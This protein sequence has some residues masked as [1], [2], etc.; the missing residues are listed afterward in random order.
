MHV[1]RDTRETKSL[2]DSLGGG[3]ETTTPRSARAARKLN[4]KTQSNQSSISGISDEHHQRPALT[5]KRSDSSLSDLSDSIDQH[6]SNSTTTPQ[7]L[8]D[9]PSPSPSQDTQHHQLSSDN[10]S[11]S[12]PATPNRF[13]KSNKQKPSLRKTIIKRSHSSS[14]GLL[15]H[16]RGNPKLNRA[17]RLTEAQKKELEQTRLKLLESLQQEEE[18]IKASQHPILLSLQENVD[19]A[20]ELRLTQARQKF[21]QLGAYLDRLNY[22]RQQRIWD[23]WKDAKI[24]LQ[25][26]MIVDCQIRLN[27]AP[28]EFLISNDTTSFSRNRLTSLLIFSRS[29]SYLPSHSHPDSR[30]SPENLEHESFGVCAGFIH[31]R[32]S[33]PEAGAMYHDKQR[34][35]PVV[36]HHKIFSSK[37]HEGGAEDLRMEGP[38]GEEPQI[39][40]VAFKDSMDIIHRLDRQRVRNHAVWQLSHRDIRDDLKLIHRH[41]RRSLHN[42]HLH[43]HPYP[44]TLSLPHP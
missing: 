9:S 29:A 43:H 37:G 34:K 19:I 15:R 20:K 2:I 40:P 31:S 32:Y 16:H 38:Q 5:P 22:E 42:H 13:M 39:D 25:T 8:I 36:Q 26:E 28:F 18:L 1:E 17:R 14:F 6:S 33:Q 27:R 44:T 4:S 41:R 3:L 12:L 23:T 21:Q 24:K 35:A 7:L 30:L 10:S 11:R